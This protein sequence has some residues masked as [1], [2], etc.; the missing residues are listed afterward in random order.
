MR[1]PPY[2]AGA[3]FVGTFVAARTKSR[4]VDQIG[5]RGKARHIDADLRR[6]DLRSQIADTGRSRQEASATADRRQGFPHRGINLSERLFQG[7]NEFQMYF[8]KPPVMRG[9]GSVSPAIS[10]SS[11][12]RPLWPSTSDKALP[13]FTFASSRIFWLRE[14]RGPPENI[15]HQLF[16]GA[17]QIAQLLERHRRH[18]A[19]ADQ[20]VGRNRLG[21]TGLS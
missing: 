3:A 18:G 15:T 8:E 6:H 13:S 16:S 5:C 1:R 2:A 4:L 10:A 17:C 20:A 21:N 14:D 9:S 19:G 7:R 11:M 12:A